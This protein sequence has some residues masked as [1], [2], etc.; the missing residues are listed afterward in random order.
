MPPDMDRTARH[1]LATVYLRVALGIAFLSAVA[2]RFGWWG[3]PGTDHVAWGNFARF[4][5]YAGRLNPWA[6]VSVVPAI[7]WIATAVEI[8]L[9]ILLV[10]GLFTRTVAWLSGSLLLLFAFGMIADSG[11][12]APLDA[13]V[14]TASAGSFVLACQ[15]SFP[16][17]LDAVVRQ[18]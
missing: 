14:F 1:S 6:P 16:W 13:S 18:P 5:A 12:K 3:A 11:I 15:P 10:V 7:A 17:S 8:A 4:T 9:G 2:D